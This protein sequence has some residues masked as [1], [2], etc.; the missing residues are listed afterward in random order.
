MKKIKIKAEKW[1]MHITL[2]TFLIT[3][4]V[5]TT[6]DLLME[7]AS[8]L[9]ATLVVLTIVLTGILFD[10]VG[11]AVAA[12]NPKPFHG[13]AA[14]KVPSA[15]YSLLLL[16]HASKVSNFFN[17]V[18]GD[19][20]G[21]ISGAGSAVIVLK[22]VASEMSFINQTYLSVLLSCLVASLTVGGKALGKDIAINY[23]KEVVHITGKFM[24]FFHTKTPLKYIIKL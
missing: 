22:V 19:I 2:A 17:D 13:M 23:S 3:M 9:F 10:T 20:A 14:A 1:V 24:W 18:I 21:V 5:S 4:I 7:N 16:K 12:G 8:I 6:T 15:K 11:T